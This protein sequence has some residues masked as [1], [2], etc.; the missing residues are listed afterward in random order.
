MN[1]TIYPSR[2]I[3]N[4]EIDGSKALT[5]RFL[6]GSILS[7]EGI[8]LDN[9]PNNDDIKATLNFLK[10]I[11]KEYIYTSENSIYVK[12]GKI[13]K[14]D[15]I[16]VDVYN[17]ASTLRFILPLSL[18]LA[19]KVTFN[20]NEQLINKTLSVYEKLT[21]QCNLNIKKENN[22]I[23]C[24]GSMNLDYYEVDGSISSQFITGLIIN[25]LYM[26]K[27]I[28]IKIIPPFISLKYV[29]MSVEVFKKLGFDIS[30]N[31][32]CLYI[33]N[34]HNY[35]WDT[36]FIEGDYSIAANYI[37]LAALNGSLV[38]KNLFDNSI[39]EEKIIVDII[40]SIGGNVRFIKENDKDILYI[41][42]NTLLE[43]GIAKQL[44]AFKFDMTSS[45]NLIPILMIIA[46][47]SN[48]ISTFT[49]L[50][51]LKDNEIDRI[52]NMIKVLRELNVSI[53]VNNDDTITIKGKKEY[54]NNKTITCFDDHR[55][56]MAL[57]VFA[58]LNKGV[59]TISNIDC[60]NKSDIN[61]FNNLIKGCKDSAIQ[62]NN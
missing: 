40:K 15:E 28:T 20:C 60:I 1:V 24:S 18:N 33:H 36:Y 17:S 14:L 11:N 25:A 41:N 16:N 58:L 47:L 48:G 23:V 2:F 37:A 10:A 21:E 9:I 38:A 39:Q 51:K 53:N 57:S 61:F 6:L 29:L 55:I 35:I 26:K 27:P 7:N 50:S 5:H 42:N 49:N 43:K 52:N 62:I 54:Y 13:N 4:K 3:L 32:N 12:Q 30:Y 45:I 34:N 59:I 56:L 46:S 44:K 19:K 8:I 22:K 31:D